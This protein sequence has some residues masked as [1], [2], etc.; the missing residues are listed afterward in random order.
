MLKIVDELARECLAI[1]VAD[2][3]KSGSDARAKAGTRAGFKLT[4]ELCQSEGAVQPT[5]VLVVG[6]G[7]V[8]MLVGALLPRY[9]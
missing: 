4:I 9:C 5:I 2:K 8:D 7:I 3:L 1:R 6:G